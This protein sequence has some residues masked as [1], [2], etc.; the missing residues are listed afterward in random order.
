MANNALKLDSTLLNNRH[1][2]VTKSNE[3]ANIFIG[4]IRKTWTQEELETKIRRIFHNI[5]KIEFFTDPLNPTKNRGFCF[6]IFNTRNEAIK[7]LNYL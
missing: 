5:N 7:A 6:G 4:N 2:K 1:I 3:N